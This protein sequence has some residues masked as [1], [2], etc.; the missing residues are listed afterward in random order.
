[1]QLI[2]VERLDTQGNRTHRPLWLMATGESLPE[3]E[4][5]WQHYLR[6][7]CVDHWYRLIKQ[8]LHWCLPYL[9]TATQTAAWSTLMPLMTW[10]LWLARHEGTTHTLPW[11]KPLTQPTPGRVANGFAS[12][13]VT[14]GDTGSGCQTSR[15]ITG[16][17]NGQISDSSKAISL[18][19]KD[20]LQTQTERQEGRITTDFCYQKHRSIMA[21]D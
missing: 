12:L 13:L 7:F 10:Q 8:R 16:M 6:R 3:L 2:L 21:I 1:M 5:L 9:G 18:G 4:T 15:K 17:A 20:L 14:L 19:K 11:Q